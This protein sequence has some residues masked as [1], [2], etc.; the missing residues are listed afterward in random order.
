[1][2][3]EEH[4]GGDDGER[5]AGVGEG[6]KGLPRNGAGSGSAEGAAPSGS[7]SAIVIC[8]VTAAATGSQ[9]PC[10]FAITRRGEPVPAGRRRRI[11]AVP[12]DPRLQA[13]VDALAG[14]DEEFVD[15]SFALILRRPADAEARERA[16]AKLRGGDALAGDAPARARDRAR[17][18]ARATARRR[19]RLRAGRPGAGRAAAPPAGAARHR[20]APRRGP[21][22][23]VAAALRPRPRGRLGLRRARLHRRPRRGGAGRAR[24]RRLA[25]GVAPG[26]EAVVADARDLPFED[27]SFD[28]VL[29]VSTLEHI[30]ADNEVYGVEGGADPS[31]RSAALHELRRVLRPSGRLLV[32]VPLGE[33]GDYGWFRQEDVAGWTRLFTGAGFFVEEQEAYELIEEGWR[34]APTFDPAGVTYG[35]RGPAASAVLCAELSPRRLRRLVTPDGMR[36]TARRRLG[37]SYRR[38]R[39]N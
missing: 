25:E 9:R 7:S 14:P 19:R 1:M 2:A 6:K 12:V 8:R 4:P 5:A 23:A 39:G 29:L 35:S 13:H 32:T 33:P 15:A 10:P 37:P 11:P 20:R 38:L 21:V 17:A 26:F 24:R 22:G 28:Q 18:R 34:S 31:G 27:A 16:L 36:R 30:G 3:D